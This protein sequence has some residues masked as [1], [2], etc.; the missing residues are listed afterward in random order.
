MQIGRND[1]CPCGSG[2]KYK[3][4]CL[5]K[6]TAPKR[7]EREPDPTM[8]TA[9]L[10]RDIGQLTRVLRDLAR[11]TPGQ[12]Q[13]EFHQLLN[14]AEPLFAYM[15]RQPEIKA[16]SSSLEAHRGAFE[17][18]VRDE[19]AHLA[20]VRTLFAE[21]RFA[22]LRFTADD[23][24]RAFQE[25]GPPVTLG[26]DDQKV[27]RLLAAILHCAT[28]D[29]RRRASLNLLLGL[30][31]YV[32]TGRPLDAWILQHCAYL[33][34]DA[35]KESNPFLF[36][37][38]ACGYDAWAAEQRRRDSALLR[39]LGLDPDGLQAMN[40]DEME[41]WLKA[42]MADPAKT[43]RMEALLLAD[44]EHRAQ[45]A[46]T[47]QE[48]EQASANLL[49]RPDAAHLLLP[50]E[51]VT[52]C[53]PLLHEHLEHRRDQLPDPNDPSPDPAALS[54]VQEVLQPFLG[55]MACALLTPERV[56]TLIAQLKTY[57]RERLAAGEKGLAAATMCAILSLEQEKDPAQNFFLLTLCFVSM[58][59]CLDTLAQQE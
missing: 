48:M 32:A 20:R 9:I 22:A 43:A 46:A 7:A 33:T 45:T 12:D 18:L 41:A 39:E 8:P 30:P 59:R 4:C 47:T 38:F 56:R 34:A 50:P 1:P 51:E 25:V 26:S 54:V 31:D 21:E 58:R 28:Q 15:E 29:Y 52:P 42:Q 36:E 3:R 2:K 17:S 19:K 37:M 5:A 55:Q 40:P 44:P 23:V 10:P 11:T 35:P 16:A 6:D 13:A 14:E 57:H 53:L 49:R 27:E 24:R